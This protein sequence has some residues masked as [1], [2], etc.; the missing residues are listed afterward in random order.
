MSNREGEV[1]RNKIGFCL[2]KV[3]KL[4]FCSVHLHFVH[5]TL[6]SFDSALSSKKSPFGAT[7]VVL[8]LSSLLLHES[9]VKYY[10]STQF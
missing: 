6:Q 10:S 5:V 9:L 7:N 1:S 3:S 2:I 4:N 8:S